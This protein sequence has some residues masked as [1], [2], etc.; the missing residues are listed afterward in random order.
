MSTR[1][2]Q[3]AAVTAVIRIGGPALGAAQSPQAQSDTFTWNGERVSFDATAKSM[4]MKSR[5]AYQEA[6]SQLKHFKAGDRRH[7]PRTD[8]IEQEPA[9]SAAQPRE[10]LSMLSSLRRNA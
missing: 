1:W 10:R 6:I 4:T 7:S 8:L 3:I 5:V 9:E 2:M